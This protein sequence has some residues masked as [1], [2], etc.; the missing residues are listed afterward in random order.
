MQLDTLPDPTDPKAA[1][2]RWQT[3][4]TGGILSDADTDRMTLAALADLRDRLGLE[5]GSRDRRNISGTDRRR[6]PL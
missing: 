6:P 3:D 4:G 1:P 5:I 2:V